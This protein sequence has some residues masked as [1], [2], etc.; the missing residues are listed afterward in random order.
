MEKDYYEILEVDKKASKE[1]IEK[2][3]KTLAKKYHPD[4]QNGQEKEEYE[5]KMKIVNEAYSVLSDEYKKS[6]YDRQLKIKVVPIEEYQNILNENMKLRQEL[7]RIQNTKS[8]YINNIEQT[9]EYQKQAEIE[10]NQ[11]INNAVN[12]AYHDAYVQDM[13]NRGYK[14]KHKKT[15]K[16]YIKIIITIVLVILILLAIAQIPPVKRFLHN[17]YEE[18][19]I[20]KAIVDTFVRTFST[21]FR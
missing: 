7:D 10:Y 4:L 20:I 3:Y 8:E 2:A 6:E 21:E 17:M 1:I 11:K 5:R 16:E 18:N 13:K 14:F 19:I 15:L 12:Q 9:S